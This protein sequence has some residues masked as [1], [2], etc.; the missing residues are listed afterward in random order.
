MRLGSVGWGCLIA[1]FHKAPCTDRR[2]LVC[3]WFVLSFRLNGTDVDSQ[4]VFRV[5]DFAAFGR[6]PFH[7]IL[8]TQQHSVDCK[9]FE[10]R[11]DALCPRAPSA[12]EA[13]L[14]GEDIKK[15]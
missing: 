12:R 4:S 1:G 8:A 9:A 13:P 6:K 3:C 10:A 5:L 14:P 11:A 15:H 7:A 2:P